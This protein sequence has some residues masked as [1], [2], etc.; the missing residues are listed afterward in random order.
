MKNNKK[1]I[2]FRKSNQKPETHLTIEQL[3]MLRRT[4]LIES[5]GASTRMEGSQ[6]SDKEVE[7]L[8]FEEK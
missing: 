6:L 2:I 5:V 1:M 8:L 7:K 4:A 3:K